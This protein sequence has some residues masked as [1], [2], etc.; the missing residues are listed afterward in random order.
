MKLE[1]YSSEKTYQ[2]ATG[3]I[4]TPEYMSERYPA[5]MMFPHIVQ[6]NGSGQVISGIY[7]LS[8]MRD[9][10]K[11]EPELSDEDAVTEIER[12]LNERLAAQKPSQSANPMGANAATAAALEDIAS[13]LTYQV[14][15][16]LRDE[17][18]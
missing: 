4:A 12:I 7:N 18:E 15:M 9:K 14:M 17:T 8:D 2:F 10:H 16:S 3:T 11:I 1:L 13:M 6:T 5:V